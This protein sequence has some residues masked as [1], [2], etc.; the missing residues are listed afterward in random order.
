MPITLNNKKVILYT[1][2]LI[3][4]S[5]LMNYFMRDDMYK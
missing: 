5:Y 4:L 2:L 1:L 3:G